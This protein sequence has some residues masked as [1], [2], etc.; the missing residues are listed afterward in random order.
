MTLN[1]DAVVFPVFRWGRNLFLKII[2]LCKGLSQPLIEELAPE[3]ILLS[4]LLCWPRLL[5]LLHLGI[6]L[7]QQ[8]PLSRAI[9]CEGHQSDNF[10]EWSSLPDSNS[11][12]PFLWSILQIRL[13]LSPLS[14]KYFFLFWNS[15][16]LT[17]SSKNS[18]ELSLSLPP[19]LGIILA[20]LMGV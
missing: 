3:F 6:C 7:P 20:V 1:M 12:T 2:Q 19:K 9:F 5:L 15:L 13:L 17:R 18:T 16:S 8:V 4:T 11:S 14:I 10:P